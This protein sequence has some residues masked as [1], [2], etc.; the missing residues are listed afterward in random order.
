MNRVLVLLQQILAV[1]AALTVAGVLLLS[2]FPE[3][4]LAT[5]GA[6]VLPGLVVASRVFP[7]AGEAVAYGVIA[8]IQLLY[9]VVL[10]LAWRR[11]TAA[12]VPRG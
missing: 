7:E 3:G 10:V 1:A 4:G 9:A 6:I 11:I 8:T 5:L 12:R 2:Y